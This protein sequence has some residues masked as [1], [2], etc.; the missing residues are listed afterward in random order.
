MYFHLIR[1]SNRLCTQYS[2]PMSVKT[3]HPIQM[4][5]LFPSKGHLQGRSSFVVLSFLIFTF[6]FPFSLKVAGEFEV[7][8]HIVGGRKR[9]RVV[10][11]VDFG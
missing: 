6:F 3:V 8:Q 9:G 4:S 7:Y 10:S 1:P 5:L 2:L 11:Q